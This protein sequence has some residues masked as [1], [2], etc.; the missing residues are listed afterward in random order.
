MELSDLMESPLADL[1]AIGDFTKGHSM[2]SAADRKLVTNPANV[3]LIEKKF[4]GCPQVFNLYFVNK[5]GLASVLETGL[6]TKEWVS[7]NLGPD[8]VRAMQKGDPDGITAIF[9]NNIA[10]EKMP[11]TPWI[12]AHR[13][14]HAF[15]RNN[16]YGQSPNNPPY[17]E[18]G[19]NLIRESANILQEAYQYDSGVSGMKSLR[20]LPYGGGDNA[21]NLFRKKQL[22]F[23]SFFE[24][25][26][27]FRS[28]RTGDLRDYFEM[29]HELLAQYIT[30]GSIH[31]KPLQRVL[32]A[33]SASNRSTLVLTHDAV[34]VDQANQAVQ[35]MAA[36]MGRDADMALD[37]GCGR[38]WV[39]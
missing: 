35:A 28:A 30:T 8:V 36:D 26:G 22:L 15:S 11:M 27:T 19:D 31:F 24:S 20:F 13:L 4:S 1:Q 16:F 23:T 39:V 10:D 3:K 5:V 25:I 18:M 34:A 38:I 21:L 29:Q 37:Y 7:D 9:T 32:K 12:I 6:V 2:R 33:G 17:T 14:G